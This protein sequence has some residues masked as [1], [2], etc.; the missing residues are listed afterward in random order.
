M[1]QILPQGKQFPHAGAF[2]PFRAPSGYGFTAFRG[3]RRD[4][5]L[6]PAAPAGRVRQRRGRMG[7]R[8]RVAGSLGR[9]AI[10]DRAS[11]RC[12]SR[13]RWCGSG[14]ADRRMVRRRLAR[15][16]RAITHRDR[17]LRVTVRRGRVRP[18][19]AH[20][21]RVR[22]VTARRGVTAA[23]GILRAAATAGRPVVAVAIGEAAAGSQFL[24]VCAISFLPLGPAP[25][26][27]G[28][29]PFLCGGRERSEIGGGGRHRCVYASRFTS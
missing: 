16:R 7:I 26:K 21:A 29:G 25:L 22:Q 13:L 4:S 10:R 1:L 23:A 8:D 20:R 27:G 28:L 12:G 11:S 5:G 2:L 9:R 6:R 24:P 14:R 17:A 19:T 18:L 15:I 3:W